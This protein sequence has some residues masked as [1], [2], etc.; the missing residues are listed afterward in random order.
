MK[1]HEI[2]DYLLTGQLNKSYLT[3][4]NWRGNLVLYVFIPPLSYR[5]GRGVV[6]LWIL[7]KTNKMFTPNLQFSY[8][9]QIFDTFLSLLI[10]C[11]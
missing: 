8:F 1:K 5:K 9:T 10:I 7:D 2:A 4:D 11:L 6:N 3:N